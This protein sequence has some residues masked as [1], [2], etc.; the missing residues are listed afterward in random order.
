MEV[1]KENEK[2][3]IKSS[4]SDLR[5]GKCDL[6]IRGMKEKKEKIKIKT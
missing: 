4:Y 6:Q 5:K 3:T 1:K 2:S